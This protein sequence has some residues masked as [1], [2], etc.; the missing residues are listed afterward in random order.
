M[1]ETVQLL[2]HKISNHLNLLPSAVGWIMRNFLSTNWEALCAKFAIWGLNE[3]HS[4]TWDQMIQ[5]DNYLEFE[6]RQSNL[7]V[8]ALGS[9]LGSP[10]YLSENAEAVRKR[11]SKNQIRSSDWCVTSVSF[12][13]HFEEKK[14]K[15]VHV[16]SPPYSNIFTHLHILQSRSCCGPPSFAIPNLYSVTACLSPPSGKAREIK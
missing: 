10:R 4:D 2:F 1:S 7:T 9:G 15:K 14:R 16:S 5:Y 12:S 13:G 11:G 3:T 8:Y 6:T